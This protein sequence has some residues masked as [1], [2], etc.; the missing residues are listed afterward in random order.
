M[1]IES[2]GTLV[3]DRRPS[4]IDHY[5]ES[6]VRRID[7]SRASTTTR[8]WRLTVVK[9]HTPHPRYVDNSITVGRDYPVYATAIFFDDLTSLIQNDFGDARWEAPYFF[10]ELD[11]RLPAYWE[12]RAFSDDG[13]TGPVRRRFQAI[14]GYPELVRHPAHNDG[15]QDNRGEDVDLV[16]PGSPAA[17]GSLSCDCRPE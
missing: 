11:G 6:Q 4:K 17:R 12:F 16:C 2:V 5:R 13:L 8:R 15:L 10:Q 7:I 14:W 1:L 9:H 3:R